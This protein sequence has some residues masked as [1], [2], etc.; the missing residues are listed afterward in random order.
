[1]IAKENF[2]YKK[3]ILIYGFGKSGFSAFNFLNKNN[4]CKIIDDNKKNIPIKFKKKIINFKKLKY[5]FF[6]YIIISPG[7]DSNKCKLSEYLKSNKFRIITDL[8]VFYLSY[9]KIKKITI[10]GTNGKST[11]SKLLFNVLKA[12]KKDVRL[13]GN[14]GNPILLEKNIKKNTI[15]IIEASSYQIEYSSF[16]RSEYSLILNLSPDHLER[17][18]NINNYIK[19]KFKLIQ[20]QTSKNY[21]FIENN[22]TYLNNLIKKNK[23]KSKIYKI[24]YNNYNKYYKFIDNYY[25]NNKSNIKNLSFIFALT[26]SLKLKIKKIIDV[27]NKFKGLKFRQQVIYKSKKLLIIN[28]SKSTSFSATKPLLESYQ[29]IY[30]I[31]GGLAKKNDKFILNRKH[32]PKIKAFIYGKDKLL[33]SKILVN[34]IKFKIS[35]NINSSLNILFNDLKKNCI[36]KKII[37]FSPSAASFDQF[38]NFE[39]RGIYFNKI[40]KNYIRKY[41]NLK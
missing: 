12:H 26:K 19:A 6:D 3:N 16:F 9:P 14:I 17:H 11:T 4:Y 37:L 28:D 32:F 24:N 41:K 27:T 31:L 5:F 40:I 22:N 1:M 30:W 8:D 15:F 21:A 2:F 20:N 25:F 18:G 7:I 34:K 29:Y 39:E 13:T 10:T 23:I 35:E 33:F 38:S 36:Q